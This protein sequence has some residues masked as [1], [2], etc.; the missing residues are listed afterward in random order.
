MN[1]KPVT[2][3]IQSLAR[4]IYIELAQKGIVLKDR[5]AITIIAKAVAARVVSRPI[6]EQVSVQFSRPIAGFDLVPVCDI[7]EHFQSIDKSVPPNFVF[8]QYVEI[9]GESFVIVP[10]AGEASNV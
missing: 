2:E 3:R 7:K 6:P 8:M 4:Q 10:T 9:M 1:K 5:E